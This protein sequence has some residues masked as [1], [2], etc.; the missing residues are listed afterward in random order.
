MGLR[1]RTVAR[2][3]G[4]FSVLPV[5]AVVLMSGVGGVAGFPALVGPVWLVVLGLGLV[6]GRHTITR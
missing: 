2:W 6:F 1:E 3:L 5:L 4:A